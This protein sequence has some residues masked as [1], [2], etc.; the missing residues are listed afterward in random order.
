MYRDNIEQAHS[1]IRMNFTQWLRVI[2][3]QIILL[4]T[5]APA[6]DTSNGE[7]LPSPAVALDPSTQ[8][9]NSIL[10]SFVED[11]GFFNFA[12]FEWALDFCKEH[13]VL[14]SKRTGQFERIVSLLRSYCAHFE[15]LNEI[16]DGCPPEF[17]DSI[18]A[19]VMQDPVILPSNNRCDRST[20]LRQL[21]VSPIDPFTKMPL[22][23]DMVKSDDELKRRI[24]AYMQQKLN[25]LQNPSG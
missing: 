25:E 1:T 9:R 8:Y 12:T 18:M 24:Y 19:T 13:N 16:L 23:M 5:N 14:S 4:V 21:S 7:E 17:Y 11:D 2:V 3:E 22:S 6:V 20:V 15:Q 10:I